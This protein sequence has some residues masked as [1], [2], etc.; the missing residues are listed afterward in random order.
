VFVPVQEL[1]TAGSWGLAD[2]GQASKSDV[3]GVDGSIEVSFDQVPDGELWLVDRMVV[4]CDS[5][6]RTRALVYAGVVDVRALR[7]GTE[8]GNFD[9]ADMASPIQLRTGDQLVVAWSSATPGAAGVAFAQWT[10]LRRS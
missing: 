8:S 2:F 4:S 5:A 6:A 9:V 3:A 7:D 10:V 1:T